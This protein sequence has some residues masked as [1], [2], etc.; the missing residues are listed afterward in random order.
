MN[1]KKKIKNIKYFDTI[2]VGGGIAGLNIVYQKI[3]PTQSYA[4]FEKESQL[5]GRISTY[6]SQKYLWEKGAARFNQNHHRLL[7]LCKE[8]NLDKK[9]QNIGSSIS[10]YPTTHSTSSF[11]NPFFYI[12][13]VY[14]YYLKHKKNKKEYE[15]KTYIEYAKNILT[16]KEIQYLLNSFGYE[17]ELIKT[18]AEYAIQLF[19]KDFLPKNQ[20]MN[21][22]GGMDQLIHQMEKKIKKKKNVSI[23]TSYQLQKI[24]FDSSLHHFLLTFTHSDKKI[25]FSCKNLVLALPKYALQKISYLKKINKD[26]EKVHC[27][28][29]MRTYAVYPP[30]KKEKVWFDEYGKVTTN[31]SLRYIIPIDKKKGVIM[32]SYTDG[33]YAQKVHKLNE[34]NLKKTIKKGVNRVLGKEIGDPKVLKRHYWNCGIGLW[35]KGKYDYHQLSK[36]MI[37]PF[38]K[39]NLYICGENYSMNQGWIE[40]ALETSY[41]VIKWLNHSSKFHN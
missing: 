20:F 31:H 2:V 11:K 41:R 23:Y 27:I 15:N 4:L 13:K 25:K 16:K 40:G 37:K 12:Q 1:I 9:I 19:H 22:K 28:P 18:N 30:K 36:K 26:L 7:S 39:E 17:S 35:K 8:L 33:Q 5:G 29:L 34:L 24:K 3:N 14:R 6:L 21:L 38:K 32:I 10:Y